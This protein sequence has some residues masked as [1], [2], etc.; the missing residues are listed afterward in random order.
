MLEWLSANIDID[1]ILC[2][3][4]TGI[5]LPTLPAETFSAI[6]TSRISAPMNIYISYNRK[7]VEIRRDP[8]QSSYKEN[9]LTAMQ[10]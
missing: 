2:T 5:G 4:S 3:L 8:F 7:S 9:E 1:L 10:G 6:C